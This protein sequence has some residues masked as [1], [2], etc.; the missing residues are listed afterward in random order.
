[1][2]EKIETRIDDVDYEEEIENDDMNEND[3]SSVTM[4]FYNPSKPINTTF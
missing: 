1:V 4:T 3:I 2:N